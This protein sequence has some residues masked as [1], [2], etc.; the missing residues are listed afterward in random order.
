MLTDE[1]LLCGDATGAGAMVELRA[2]PLRLHYDPVTGAL[3]WFRLGEREILR[4]IYFALRDRN[5]GTVPGVLRERDRKIEKDSFRIQFE[6]EHRQDDINFGWCGVIEGRSDGSVRFECDGAVRSAF[7][8]NRIGFCV[9]HPIRECAGARAR[10]IRTDGALM[11]GNL[12][13]LIEPQIFG[14][15]TFQDLRGLAHEIEP[16]CWAELDFEGDVFEMEDQRNWTDASFKT[17]CTPLS[18]P[19]PVEVHPGERVRQV[20][21]FRLVQDPALNRVEIVGRGVEEMLALRWRDGGEAGPI[22]EI[23]LGLSLDGGPL[24]EVEIER[25]AA[26]RLDHLRH[27]VRLGGFPGCR[28]WGRP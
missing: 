21:K 23:G 5:W 6:C 24:S 13:R 16:G 27:D 11:D 20:I 14:K 17:Y 3:R 2:G 1:F 7:L 9:L 26:L 25:L 28:S 19:F 22:P 15:A 10:Q 18:R 4:G 8:K 12:P